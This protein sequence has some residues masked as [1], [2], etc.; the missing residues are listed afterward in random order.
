MRLVLILLVASG[1][2]AGAL[3]GGDEWRPPWVLLPQVAVGIEYGGFLL[4][5]EDYSSLFRY[6]FLIDLWK[7]NRHLI[8]TEID[9]EISFGTPQ[10]PLAFNRIRHH[11]AIFGYRYDL[12]NSYLGLRLY[13]RCHSPFREQEQLDYSLRR[14]QANTY[15]IGP[16]FVNKA[17]L[18][19]QADRGIIFDRAK[20]LEFL[21]RWH[22]AFHLNRV[23]YREFNDLNWLLEGRVRFDVL[24]YGLFIPYLEAGGEILSR[25]DR[26]TFIPRVEGGVR[27]HGGR[28]EIIPFIRWGRTEEWLRQTNA[29]EST[30]FVSR[31][32]LLGGGRLEF[33]FDQETPT[34]HP[35]AEKLQF[36]PEVHGQAG[37]GLYLGSRY[38]Q[39]AG[40][41]ELDIDLIG[42]QSLIL[43]TNLGM[44]CNTT[45]I[46]LS[47][48]ILRLWLEYGLRYSWSK[49]F[50]EGFLSHARRMETA[51]F[52]G[53]KESAHQIG[54]RVGS[55]G[56]LP[57]HYDDGISFGGPDRFAWLNKLN[58]QLSLAYCFDA[59]EWPY[60]W[61]LAAQARWDV[62]RWRFLVPYFQGGVEWLAHGW[63]GEDALGYYIEQGLRLRGVLDLAMF[64]RF[65]HRETIWSFRGPKGN[66]NLI[67]IRVL[68]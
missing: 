53:L 17:M 67:G 7:Y 35:A 25:R 8:Y 59:Y 9:G 16:E 47:I 28:V 41:V 63:G 31:S 40:N 19:G 39:G 55:R 5:G 66:F 11:L 34:F 50:L 21:G 42:W 24:R 57:G 12:G 61:N 54:V 13:H 15:A 10:E 44:D 33:L 14:T 29:L 3:E 30:Y 65:Q 68:F 48:D 37:Y 2:E 51:E 4:R 6:H 22:V 45:K 23:F 32:Y 56:M 62:L 36:F 18:V 38:H 60:K 52:R 27:F 58:A 20:P 26:W 46:D 49:F 43:F 1:Q 64:Y